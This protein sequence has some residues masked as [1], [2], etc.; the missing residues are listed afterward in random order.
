MAEFCP[1]VRKQIPPSVNRGLQKRYV[2][3][4]ISIELNLRESLFTLEHLNCKN[5]IKIPKLLKIFVINYR[6]LGEPSYVYF[7]FGAFFIYMF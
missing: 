3:I 7:D 6:D 1:N 2:C 5:I 4:D